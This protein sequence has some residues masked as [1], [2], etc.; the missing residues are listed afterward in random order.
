MTCGSPTTS[1]YSLIELIITAG[2]ENIAPV[3]IEN[4]IKEQLHI[5]SNIMVIGDQKKYLACLL[6]LKVRNQGHNA[7]AF[8]HVYM[9]SQTVVDDET[10]LPTDR[11]T[12]LAITE[13]RLAGSMATTVSE[14]TYGKDACVMKMIKMG[15]DE[16]NKQA[17]SKTHKVSTTESLYD[18]VSI[19]QQVTK[20][21]ILDT[22]FSV[23]GGELS[24]FSCFYF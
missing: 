2:G 14:I 4:S 17:T 1:L 18:V 16:A 11:L 24:K 5:V 7:N 20:W 9:L 12:D 19:T 23:A 22:D 8:T 3:P 13:C 6:T 21:V 10:G 15:I